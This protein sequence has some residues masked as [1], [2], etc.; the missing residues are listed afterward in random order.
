MTDEVFPRISGQIG[1]PIRL[2]VTFLKNGIPVEPFAVRRIDIFKE[3]VRDENLVAQIIIP[4][5]DETGFPAPIEF[6]TENPGKATL[7]FDVPADF[8]APQIYFDEWHFI[9]EDPG[10]EGDLDDESLFLKQCNR[11]FI[12]QGGFFLDDG[13]IVPRFGFEALDL[14]FRKP[15]VRSLEVG[16]MP[17]PLYD[18]DF[19]RIAPIIPQLKA[20]I[21]I[22]TENNEI[23]VDD[24]PMTIGLKQ[25]SFRSNPFVV[26]FLLDTSTFFIGSFVYRIKLLLPNGE[27]RI[28]DDL[29]L[30]IA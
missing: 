15:E 8:E 2:D 13:L 21:T 4:K 30:S 10:S 24:A 17:L 22:K 3:S 9:G 7:I 1:S 19:N 20:F 23:I 16:L 12:F 26:R 29:F 28:S 25:G 27:T 5:P 11:F 18:F 6:D 14:K